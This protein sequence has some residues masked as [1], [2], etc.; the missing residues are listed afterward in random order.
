MPLTTAQRLV[1]AEEALHKLLTGQRTVSMSY[2][3]RTV[4]YN[5]QDIGKLQEYI[6]QL[7]SEIAQEAGTSTRRPFGVTW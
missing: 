6:R 3:G 7:K 2:N 1:E 5:Q 4:T